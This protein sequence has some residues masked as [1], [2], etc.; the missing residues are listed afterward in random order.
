MRITIDT[1]YGPIISAELTD[2]ECRELRDN[3][4]SDLEE[5]RY[6]SFATD[7]GPVLVPGAVLRQ[8]LIRF[9]KV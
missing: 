7:E 6:L 4:T 3:I 9:P 5:I 1:P 8:C 2:E